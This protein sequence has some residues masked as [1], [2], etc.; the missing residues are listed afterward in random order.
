MF[1]SN[2][3]LSICFF[4]LVKA[5]CSYLILDRIINIFIPEYKEMELYLVLFVVF[6]CLPLFFLV[7]KIQ[8]KKLYLILFLSMFPEIIF[9]NTSAFVALYK[10]GWLI[11]F[12]YIYYLVIPLILYIELLYLPGFIAYKKWIVRK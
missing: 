1:S 11:F 6:C 7:R 10:Y 12:K 5:I 9:A 2:R 4:M 8:R 3:F